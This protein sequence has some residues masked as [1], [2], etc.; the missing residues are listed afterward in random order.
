MN[1]IMDLK[2]EN[3]NLVD[4]KNQYKEYYEKMRKGL[5]I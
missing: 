4:I 5:I 2:K 1:E 3:D